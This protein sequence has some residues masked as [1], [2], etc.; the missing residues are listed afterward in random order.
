MDGGAATRFP[1]TTTLGSGK[2]VKVLVLS[3]AADVSLLSSAAAAPKQSTRIKSDGTFRM[4]IVGL[5]I[6][7]VIVIVVLGAVVSP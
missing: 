3:S 5:I 6:D 2:V 1:M 7:I 4:T